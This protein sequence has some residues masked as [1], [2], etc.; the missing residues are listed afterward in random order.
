MHDPAALRARLLDLRRDTL[1]QLAAADTPDAGL[2]RLVADAHTAL[3]ALDAVAEDAGATAPQ[4]RG[5]DPRATER[6]QRDAALRRLAAVTGA[7]VP[8][9]RVA[10]DL[11]G[12]LARYCPMPAETAPERLLMREIVTSGPPVPGPD[13]LARILRAR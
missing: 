5:G 11:A 9:E 12:R 13:R 4:P 3:A 2:M 6:A 7:D 8:T 10:R 1:H